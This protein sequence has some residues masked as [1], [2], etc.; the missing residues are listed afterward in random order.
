MYYLRKDDKDFLIA[1]DFQQFYEACKRL[2][3]DEQLYWSMVER[4]KERC[5]NNHYEDLSI[6]KDQWL[7]ALQSI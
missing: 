2:K 5:S 6:V 4:A 7:E 1:N 3:T